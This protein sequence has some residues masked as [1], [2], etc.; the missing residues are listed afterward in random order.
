MNTERTICGKESLNRTI[1]GNAITT[2][3]PPLKDA[4]LRMQIPYSMEECR[5]IDQYRELHLSRRTKH[6][7][8]SIFSEDAVSITLK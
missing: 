4:L 2:I 1:F 3:T 7:V 8:Q 6:R 5:F